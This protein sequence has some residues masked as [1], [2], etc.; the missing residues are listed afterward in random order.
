MGC[1]N[2]KPVARKEYDLKKLVEINSILERHFLLG[3]LST[4]VLE[5]ASKG[6]PWECDG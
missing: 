3:S 4:A 6:E 2:H 1:G 5:S